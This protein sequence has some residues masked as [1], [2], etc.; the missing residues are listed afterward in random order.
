MAYNFFQ[1]TNVNVGAT[2]GYAGE[3]AFIDVNDLTTIAEPTGPFTTEGASLIITADHVAAAGKGFIKASLYREGVTVKSKTNGDPGFH[4][5]EYSLEGFL[6]GDDAA[7]REKAD[8]IKNRGFIVLFK[9]PNCQEER[10]LQM[11]CKCSPAVG[12][13]EFES[14]NILSGNKKGYKITFTVAPC[15]IFDYKGAITYKS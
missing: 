2:P 8:N 3:I 7:T 4:V 12:M 5:G 13:S 6:V 9:D 14:G 11:G 10:W 1:Q 15:P